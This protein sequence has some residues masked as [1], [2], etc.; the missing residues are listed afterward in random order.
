MESVNCIVSCGSKNIVMWAWPNLIPSPRLRSVRTFW[1]SD[2]Y[3]IS[4][5]RM[6]F[7]LFYSVWSM[8]WNGS[9]RWMS[10][11]W[12]VMKDMYWKLDW[13]RWVGRYKHIMFNHH[14]FYCIVYIYIPCNL[15]VSRDCANSQIARNMYTCRWDILEFKMLTIGCLNKCD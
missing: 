11:V 7:P 5:E 1:H 3:H 13:S 15:R 10:S 14:L 9:V 4:S 8:L 2:C 12:F 6:I